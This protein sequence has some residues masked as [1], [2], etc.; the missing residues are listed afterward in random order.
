MI[1]DPNAADDR[2]VWGVVGSGVMSMAPALVRVGMEPC[3]VG[4]LVRGLATAAKA[5]SRKGSAHRRERLGVDVLAVVLKQLAD[6]GLKGHVC[7]HILGGPLVHRRHRAMR[8]RATAV[9]V[10]Q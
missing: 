7:L 3:A 8:L 1:E 9:V 6:V 2:S 4:S 5:W 10:E